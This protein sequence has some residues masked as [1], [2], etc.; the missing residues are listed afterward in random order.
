MDQSREIALAEDMSDEQYAHFL[1]LK[2]AADITDLMEYDQFGPTVRMS[3]DRVFPLMTAS[4]EARLVQ[5]GAIRLNQDLK[6]FSG[7][8]WL[9]LDETPNP[10]D[11][12][13]ELWLMPICVLGYSRSK[14]A[15]FE[16]KTATPLCRSYNGIYP[17]DGDIT[18][19]APQCAEVRRTAGGY[20]LV[21]LCP[22]AKKMN[23]EKAACTL[24]LT[25]AFLEMNRCL[26]VIMRFR[27]AGLSAFINLDSSLTKAMN[28]ARIRK[29]NLS[30]IVVHLTVAD[31]GTYVRPVLAL[32]KAP[33]EFGDISEYRR[34][35]AWYRSELFTNREDPEA[36]DAEIVGEANNSKAEA[37]DTEAEEF[38]LS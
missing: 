20:R 8:I 5:P 18:P 24:T 7:K 13:D 29:R 38:D 12:F 2:A 22:S 26:P 30:D 6:G 25:V 21:T 32:Q 15:K 19:D 33:E 3:G 10:E 34:L 28:V 11:F 1:P 37:E 23:G 4:F 14:F 16:N 31:E 27:G 9:R 17:V 36:E 35:A